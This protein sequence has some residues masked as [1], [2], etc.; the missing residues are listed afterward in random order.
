MASIACPTSEPKLAA[1]T[2]QQTLAV[3][4]MLADSEEPQYL[5]LHL[6]RVLALYVYVFL[7]QNPLLADD[8]LLHHSAELSVSTLERELHAV[9]LAC[10]EADVASNQFDGLVQE[11]RVFIA[12]K[13]LFRLERVKPATQCKALL[14]LLASY[15]TGMTAPIV[16]C[17]P[18]SMVRST[19]EYLAT[20]ERTTKD[21]SLSLLYPIVNAVDSLRIEQ[22]ECLDALTT[23]WKWL[24]ARDPSDQVRPT[25][26]APVTASTL[27]DLTDPRVRTCDSSSRSL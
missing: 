18:V 4:E 19:L 2:K 23:L 14:A 15:L 16:T 20:T 3:T 22:R 25:A 26:P 17:A 24:A 5:L 9:L 7:S 12:I 6:V 1:T 13:K 27:S 10:V 21:V 8:A 11:K